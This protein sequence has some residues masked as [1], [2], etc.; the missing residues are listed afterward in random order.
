MLESCR[1]TVQDPSALMDTFRWIWYGNVVDIKHPAILS[2]ML[3]FPLFH[4]QVTRFL[5]MPSWSFWMVLLSH[6]SV[7]LI[8]WWR[9][10]KLS[11]TNRICYLR[12][13]R[14]NQTLLWLNLVYLDFS[15]GM[16]C[17]IALRIFQISN[18]DANA[19]TLYLL[20]TSC[21]NVSFDLRKLQL[22]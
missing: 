8:S 3:R 15:L 19:K 20:I 16:C 13:R 7:M 21:I 14:S 12:I 11:P 1:A 6:P 10:S 2:G 4:K 22:F 9:E 18:T 17:C 5:V